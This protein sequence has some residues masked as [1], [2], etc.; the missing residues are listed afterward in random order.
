MLPLKKSSSQSFWKCSFAVQMCR[1]QHSETAFV[2][3]M[4]RSA[5]NGCNLP[6]SC[7]EVD[8]GHLRE[9]MCYF[10]TLNWSYM[11]AARHWNGFIR[12][13]RDIEMM[14]FM[15]YETLKW[16]YLWLVKKLADDV[17]IGWNWTSDA[18]V[19][20]HQLVTQ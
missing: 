15:L 14:L 3:I 19:T 7:I 17:Q 1:R 9:E 4:L 11:C 16:S 5:F 2:W 10:E 8:N 6:E 12:G 20:K 18:T 13:M